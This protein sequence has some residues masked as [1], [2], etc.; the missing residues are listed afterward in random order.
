MITK[1]LEGH[2]LRLHSNEKWAVGTIAKHLRVHHTVVSRVLNSVDSDGRIQVLRPSLIDP[3]LPFIREQLTK[4]PDLTASRLHGMCVARGYSGAADHFRFRIRCLRPRR[5]PEAFLRLATLPGD[6]GQVDWGHFGKLKVG[7]AERPLV[8]FVMVLSYSRRIHLSFHLS[9]ETGVFLSAHEAAFAAFGGVPRVLLYDNLKS[10]VIERKGEH[11]R[12]NE[13]M[14]EFASHHRYEPRPVA[15][16]RGN[17]KG[18]VERAI[19]YIRSSFFAG[20]EF[21]GLEDLNARAKHWCEQ[22]A[23]SRR[24]VEDETLSVN[25]ALLKE[26]PFL[27]RL[28]DAGFPT[29]A[30]LAVRIG[31]TPF[32]RVDGN[33]YTVP[34]ENVCSEVTAYLT[35]TEVLLVREGKEIARHPRSWSRGERV[36]NA[37]HIEALRAMKKHASGASATDRL[38]ALLPSAHEFFTE[39]HRQGNNIGGTVG[40]LAHCV[41]QYGA[42]AAEKALKL[43]L[44]SD[45]I[46]LHHVRTQLERLSV[47]EGRHAHLVHMPVSPA[48]AQTPTPSL[49]AWDRVGR[50]EASP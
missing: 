41:E 22:V 11:I 10:A 2:I 36:E 13:R 23:G 5:V 3:F 12:F 8:A 34:H 29:P 19:R 16:R 30:S 48:C 27:G 43:V 35:E 7:R 14:I 33:D 32:A 47:E 25:D 50:K 45:R 17:E 24:H 18:R 38:Q 39:M 42:E 15:V 49:A 26:R 21:N 44:V 9:M 46:T 37:A 1:D 6:E 20:L 40:S 4:Y 31:K 28:P